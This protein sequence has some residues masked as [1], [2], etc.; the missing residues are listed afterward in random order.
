MNEPQDSDGLSAFGFESS[1]DTNP[2]AQARPILRSGAKDGDWL[3]SFA[4]D[5]TAARAKNVHY[6]SK[7]AFDDDLDQFAP[8]APPVVASDSDEAEVEVEVEDEP[9][10]ELAAPPL[11]LSQPSPATVH[12]SS[13]WARPWVAAVLGIV[14][15]VPLVTRAVYAVWGHGP[16]TPS[17]LVVPAVESST[18]SSAQNR[19]DAA[20][21]SARRTATSR[22]AARAS[23]PESSQ[24]AVR[25]ALRSY[26]RAYETLDVAAAAAI[27]PSVD[28]S[29]LASAFD[30][31]KS[32][33]LN[34][35]SCTITVLDPS[36]IARCRG[37]L[38]IVRKIDGSI[39][40]TAEQE[41]VFKMRRLGEEWK[42]EDVSA[43]Q[44]RP[45]SAP[46]SHS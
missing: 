29:A 9:F 31:L 3:S 22:D 11:H 18:P 45:S 39:P 17:H 2:P 6:A 41:W 33:G 19:I 43:S 27:W 30:T 12:R 37:T 4:I 32:Q 42:I 25:T 38:E 14:I 36:A 23:A 46:R 13:S 15:S 28:R 21:A 10:E 34:F 20:A 35:K 1:G 40:L 8:G 7:T 16:A 44:G 24:D 5:P 26:E